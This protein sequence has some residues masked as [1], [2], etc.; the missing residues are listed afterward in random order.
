MLN[1]FVTGVSW[2]SKLFAEAGNQLWGY[3]TGMVP[4][5]VCM[6]AFFN[7]IISYIGQDRIEAFGRKLCKHEFLTYTI[8]P[9]IISAC[10]P[11][12]PGVVLAGKFVPEDQKLGFLDAKLTMVHPALGLFP[13]INASNYWVFAGLAAGVEALGYDSAQFAV[14]ALLSAFIM[15][16]IRAY[17]TKF[18]N[19]LIKG[20]ND[21]KKLQEAAE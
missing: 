18:V 19:S 14:R 21:K 5:L 15:M 13:H 8:L 4:M 7:T 20:H 2:F 16:P 10:V 17:S 11:Q 12:T 3:I 6:L 9:F 1:A